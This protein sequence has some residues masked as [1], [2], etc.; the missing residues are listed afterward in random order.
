MKEENSFINTIGGRCGVLPSKL[1][2]TPWLEALKE[3]EGKK[4]KERKH[5]PATATATARRCLHLPPFPFPFPFPIL[6]PC[7]SG[8]ACR[9]V[10]S[11]RFLMRFLYSILVLIGNERINFHCTIRGNTLGRALHLSHSV[12]HYL[13]RC[14]CLS[15]TWK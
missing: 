9:C 12:S 4:K 11:N 1:L 8:A 5:P 2:T 13:L 14:L 15:G 10:F 3:S 6:S 7:R